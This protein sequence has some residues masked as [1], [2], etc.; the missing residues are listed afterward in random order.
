MKKSHFPIGLVAVVVM[1]TSEKLTKADEGMWLFNNPP[2][3]IL[4]DK[5]QFDATD[6][7]LEHVQKSSVRFN[8]GGSGSFV[9]A[10]GL[11]MTNHHVGADAL[12]K[13]GD[14]DHNYIRDGFHVRTS[15]EEK[16]CHDLELNVLMSIEDVTEQVN[17]AVKPDMTPEQAFPARRKII[18]EIEK[19]SQDETKLRSN[20]ITLYQGGMYQL[21]RFKRYQQAAFYGGDPD[22]FEYPR[23]DLDICFFRVYEDDKAVHP[24]HYLKWSKAGAGEG[25]LVFVSGHPGRTDRLD[26]MDE[27]HYLRDRGFPYLLQ[28][29]NRLEVLL[30]SWSARSDE[31]ARKAKELLFGVQNS[32]KARVGG[33]AGLMDPYIMAKKEAAEKTLRDA[34]ANDPKLKDAMS[35]WDA[36]AKAEKVR[37]ENA[38]QAALLESGTGFMCQQFSI[39]RTLLRAAE[40]K[41]KPNGERL[42]EYADSNLAPLEFQ[43]FSEEPTYNDFEIL[44]LTDSLTYLAEQMGYDNEL[45]QKVLAGKSPQQ[46]AYELVSGSKLNDVKVRKQLYEGGAKAID[47]STDPMIALA[48]LVDPAA[49]AVRKIMETQVDEVKRQAYAKIA[50]A[51]FA[52]EGTNSYP[53]ATFTLRLAFG[54][55]KGYEQEGQHIPFQT[56]FAGLYQR[57]EEH[58][59]KFPFDL[60]PRWVERKDKLDLKTPFNFVCTADIIGGNSGS[61]VINKEAELVGIIFDGNIQ[62]LVLDYIYT[63][64]QARA[65]SVHSSGIIEALRKMYEAN[66]LA[67]ELTGRKSEAATQ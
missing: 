38:K 31:N 37:G 15:A 19:K 53:D 44:K 1:A 47:E 55:V 10:D 66:D 32:R 42:R 16:R 43:L 8:S 67:D 52:V 61:P 6:K 21:Y 41:P 54:V 35:A 4:K 40:E 23:Y 34:V 59:N 25:E 60:P 49:R 24:Q 20:V 36:V 9:S 39:A 64:D 26:T 7:W 12:Q 33:L 63:D 13:F 3:K 56:D 22:N 46:R 28:R 50:K 17:A 2:R 29:L 11:V 62:S 14:K 65:V 57:A 30:S 5:Y 18:A 45:V 27:L 58:H 51:K 48:K